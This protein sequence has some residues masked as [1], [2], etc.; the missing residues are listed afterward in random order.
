MAKVR[1]SRE[2]KIKAQLRHFDY[3]YEVP[4]SLIKSPGEQTSNVAA[5]NS[6]AQ[7]VQTRAYPYLKHDL[8]KTVI[9]T[10]GIL[11]AQVFTLLLLKNNTIS[12]PGIGY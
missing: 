10:G 4:S 7:S 12:I 5:A 6:V 8:L 9:V 2:Q 11:V 3:H 1:R